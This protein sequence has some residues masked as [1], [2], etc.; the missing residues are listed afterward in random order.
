M[1][2]AQVYIQ[3]TSMKIS[4]SLLEITAE[5]QLDHCDAKILNGFVPLLLLPTINYWPSVLDH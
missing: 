4:V 3:K 1:S 2:V 5:Y